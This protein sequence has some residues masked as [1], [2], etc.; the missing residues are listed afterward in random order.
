MSK[1]E[2]DADIERETDRERIGEPVTDTDRH[3]QC[4]RDTDRH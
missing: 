2:N 4:H 1:R 3:I